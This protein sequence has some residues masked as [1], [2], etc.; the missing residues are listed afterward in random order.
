ML[1]SSRSSGIVWTVQLVWLQRNKS[2]GDQRGCERR[3]KAK[4]YTC[5]SLHH[6]T[7]TKAT[8]ALNWPLDPIQHQSNFVGNW[9]S[10]LVFNAAQRHI[11]LSYYYT[12]IEGK[13]Q[14]LVYTKVEYFSDTVFSLIRGLLFRDGK[15]KGKGKAIP[16]QACTGP[17]GSRRLRFPDFKTNGIWRWQGCQ[18]Y[19]PVAFTPR[20]YSWYSFLLEAESFRDVLELKMK[21][22]SAELHGGVKILI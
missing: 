8:G 14:I 5:P 9:N 10:S 11:S 4:W 2:A 16:L 7:P 19:A 17:E 3:H 6:F 1:F 20:K 18:P 13:C 15:G 21:L 22:I 12:F